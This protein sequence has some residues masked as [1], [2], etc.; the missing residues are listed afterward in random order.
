MDAARN[1]GKARP[2]GYTYEE[3]QE[4]AKKAGER[5]VPTFCSMC[6]PTAGCGIYAFEKNGRLTGVAGM[7]EA[8]RN[9]GAL[10]PKAYASSEWLHSPERLTTPL[11]RTGARG[12]GRFEPISWDD[13]IGL[14]AGK[15]LEQKSKYGPES[16]AIL[17]PAARN[18]K[19]I[20]LRFLTVH[21]SPNNG[22]SGICHQQRTFAFNY[23]LGCWPLPDYAGSELIVYWG[24]QPVFSGPATESARQL[25]DAKRRG[26]KIMSIK[27][28]MEADVALAD[29]W[30]APRP[31]TDAALALAMLHVVTGEGLTDKRFV[32]EHCYGYDRLE[33]HVRQYGP[34]WA[35]SIT[36]VPADRIVEAA[37]L[38]ATTK[39]A[40]IDLGNGVEHAPS[41]NDAI[42]AVAILIAIT[43][44]L[45]RPGCNIIIDPSDTIKPR[46]LKRPD[47]FTREM[48]DKL[49]GPE[50][51]RAFQ[52][53]MGGLSSAY[54]RVF[55][56][57]LTGKPYAPRAIIAPGTQ[58]LAS[59]RGT[60]NVIEAL[61]KVEFFVTADVSRPAEMAYADIVLPTT[62]PYESDHPFEVYGDWLM[63]QDF[64]DTLTPEAQA[65]IDARGYKMRDISGA[66]NADEMEMHKQSLLAYGTNVYELSDA[67]A[68]VFTQQIKPLFEEFGSKTSAYG[69]DILKVIYKYQG[70]DWTF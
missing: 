44:H 33:A 29:M 45:D 24:K 27:P 11:R 46:S 23:T 4:M 40:S 58:P 1:G 5:A 15:L 20:I 14:I 62:A 13:A 59:T 41:S 69:L 39:A 61:K 12:D 49:V 51:P 68:K 10:C 55:D 67:E 52:P 70:W 22:H 50:F 32:G 3:A 26:A 37:R 30:L 38:Y 6:G 9:C 7:A 16:L 54:Y 2:A 34:Q 60:K 18:Y 19:D 64:Y 42:R 25:V 28:S 66:T 35:E 17:S 47:L 8:P 63:A 21:G 65:A 36:G 57:V 56:S 43:G 48:V 53:F 31:G